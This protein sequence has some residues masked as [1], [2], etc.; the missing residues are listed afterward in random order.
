M[1]FM[2]RIWFFYPYGFDS[3][4]SLSEF[5]SSWYDSSDSTLAL[6]YTVLM[7]FIF[8]SGIIFFFNETNMG[9]NFLA[10][11]SMYDIDSSK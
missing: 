4:A 5:M 9:I 6:L 3:S 11:F 1:F 10:V 7:S 8:F 2:S